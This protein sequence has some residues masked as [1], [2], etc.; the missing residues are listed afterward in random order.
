[1]NKYIYY[2]IRHSK[3]GITKFPDEMPR[4]YIKITPKITLPLKIIDKLYFPILKTLQ[5][6]LHI[7]H[8]MLEIC[9]HSTLVLYTF[10]HGMS[11]RAEYIR[12]S[13]SSIYSWSIQPLYLLHSK[14]KFEWVTLE[15]MICRLVTRLN[16]VTCIYLFWET[17]YNQ[18]FQT[19]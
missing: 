5:S 3:G 8:V 7:A 13:P 2:D 17:D 11:R 10:R 9:V 19:N 4:T 14:Y 18:P 16:F 15:S 12:W 1:M 6:I